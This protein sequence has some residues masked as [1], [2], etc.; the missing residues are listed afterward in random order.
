MIGRFHSER[1][2]LRAAVALVLIVSACAP[3]EDI[4]DPAQSNAQPIIAGTTVPDGTRG[5]V[6]LEVTGGGAFCSGTLLTNNW[7]LTAAHCFN[8]ASLPAAGTITVRYGTQAKT[9]TQVL[10]HPTVATDPVGFIDAALVLVGSP[11]TINGATTGYQQPLYAGTAEAALGA[12]AVCLGYGNNVGPYGAGSGAGPL[13]QGEL[14]VNDRTNRILWFDAT[15][16]NNTGGICN[17]DSGGPC[18]LDVGGSS[19]L[20]GIHSYADCQTYSALANPVGYR[21]WVLQ[22]VFGNARSAQV[23]CLGPACRSMPAGLLP[24]N[25]NTSRAWSPCNGGCFRWRAEHNLESGYDFL[26]VGG[27]SMTGNGVHSGD[28]C[29]SLTVSA[30]TDGSVQS[31]GF[32]LN[33][34]CTDSDIGVLAEGSCADPEEN[35]TIHMTDEAPSNTSAVSGWV[36]SATSGT[37]LRFCRLYGSGFRQLATSTTDVRDRYSVLRLGGACPNG[38]FAWSRRFD[39][40]DTGNSNWATGW[41]GPNVV[42]TDATLQ[43][44]FFGGGTPTM[45]GFPVIRKNAGDNSSTPIHYG[46]LG[47]SNLYGALA[48]GSIYTD[49]EDTNNVDQITCGAQCSRIQLSSM[50][51][52]NNTLLYTVKVR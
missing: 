29:G 3:V 14:V 5:V 36:G 49:D 23:A 26:S 34:R 17:G 12:R 4:S 20:L 46:V 41:L 51:A 27:I 8:P 28:A 6:R 42:N 52:N 15:D 31:Q 44:C 38:S 11:F 50:F 30:T 7:V 22:T 2:A 19:Q 18:F 25:L 16:A 1:L 13:R 43:F 45:S 48:S 39:N 40:E 33:A 21:D 37:M 47:P 35:V 24:N 10:L 9:H 32:T